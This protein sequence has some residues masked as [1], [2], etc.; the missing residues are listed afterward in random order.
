MYC[1]ASFCIVDEGT[2]FEDDPPFPE[3]EPPLLELPPFDPPF[4]DPDELVPELEPPLDEPVLA[5][6]LPLEVACDA[7]FV[8]FVWFPTPFPALLFPS[9]PVKFEN[10]GLSLFV[11]PYAAT[12]AAIHNTMIIEIMT[13][14]FSNF[15]P[16]SQKFFIIL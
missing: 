16:P 1:A 12:A 4:E 6:L 3:L 2:T 13:F 15:S 10:T 11:I 14:D 9:I 8:T 7:G 5:P